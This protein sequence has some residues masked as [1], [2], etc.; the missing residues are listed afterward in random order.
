[1]DEGGALFAQF[2]VGKVAVAMTQRCWLAGVAY[3]ST[4]RGEGGAGSLKSAPYE[5]RRASD[6]AE[7]RG[8]QLRRPTWLTLESAEESAWPR[9]RRRWLLG[10]RSARHR[11]RRVRS[12]CHRHGRPPSTSR[13]HR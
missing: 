12:R 8:R 9:G 4:P 7:E 5:F 6:W 1:I 13:R 2:A 3:A 10:M 11:L